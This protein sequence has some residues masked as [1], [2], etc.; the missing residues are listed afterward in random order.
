MAA[1]SLR[2]AAVQAPEF[3][4]DMEAAL[5]YVAESVNLARLREV[6]LLCFPEAF[7]QGYLTDF[8]SAQRVALELDSPRFQSLLSHIP[9]EGPDIVLGLIERE[10][11]SIFNSAVIIR[12]RRVSGH[13][14]KQH[15]LAAEAAFDAG[16]GM[17]VFSLG[18]ARFGVNICYDT[19]FPSTARCVAELGAHLIVCPANNM[20][21]RQSAE[22][23][24]DIHNAVRAE[25]CR[26]SGLWLLSSDITG[27]RDGCVSWG[28][29][30]LINPQGEVVAQLPLGQPG[31]LVADIPLGIP[32]GGD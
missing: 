24:K 11:T 21:R 15:L 30:A 3:R 20:M 2:V 6:E 1:F 13:Y 18:R 17:G 9:S 29:T 31:M 8:E 7:L 25:R 23:Y 22:R 28:P 32:A 26:E 10:G 19:N 16:K 14:R 12:G 4:D 27:E 5:A